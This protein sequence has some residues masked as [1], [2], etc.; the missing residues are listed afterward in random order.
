MS[1]ESAFI[2]LL[3]GLPLHPG[4]RGLDDDAAVLEVGGETLVLTHDML[5]EGIHVLPGQ[6]PADVAWKLVATNLSDLAAKG[7]EP[8]GVLVGYMLGADDARFLEGLREVLSTYNT[9]LLGGDTVSGGP[10]RSFGLTAIGRATHV[11]V[12]SRSGARP[13]DA[14]YVTGPLGAA[15]AGFEALQAGNLNTA[16]PYRRP[17]PLLAE[18][19]ALA[20][21]VGAMMDVSDGL[22]L[23]SWRMAKASGTTFA[24]D[25]SAPPI[26]LPEARR[27]EALRWGDDYQLLFTMPD[28]VE[29][30]VPATRI[31]K[32][33]ARADDA[34]LVLDGT[35]ISS[36][37]GL[38][39]SH[40]G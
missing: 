6:D 32:V 2:D 11:P 9:P 1:G 18:G 28:G 12:P 36:P 35:P 30:P 4:A 19:R 27:D 13:G 20:P 31:G 22:L 14:I 21:I 34:P 39:Y 24:I 3:R 29:P 16:L 26:V 25:R 37:E 7:A 38:G 40:G 17:V 33:K 5:V 15:L 8:M 23:D 10:P